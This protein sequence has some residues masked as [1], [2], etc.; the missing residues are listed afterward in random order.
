MRRMS[1]AAAPALDALALVP[2]P[3]AAQSD[4]AAAPGFS[5]CAEA[6]ANGDVAIPWFTIG[7]VC[8]P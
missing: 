6:G 7:V 2:A 4:A 5:L 8:G 1:H 3:A